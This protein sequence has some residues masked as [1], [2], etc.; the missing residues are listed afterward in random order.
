MSIVVAD[1]D[2]LTVTA[3]SGSYG[4]V[5]DLGASKGQ[6]T[7]S[8]RAPLRLGPGLYRIETVKGTVSHS[9]D[10]QAVAALK[11]TLPRATE[12]VSTAA[13]VAG[14][15]MLSDKFKR[16]AER[17]KAVPATL[18]RRADAALARFDDID[19][20]SEVFDK[21]D[22]IAT[23]AEQSVAAAEDAVNQLTNGGS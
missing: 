2:V 8:A 23:D 12:I 3:E 19:S 22:A 18:S 9:L 14:A 7:V 1:G 6:W 10:S 15:V 21:L 16:L 13:N 4:T 5:F 11:A 17:A 20:R